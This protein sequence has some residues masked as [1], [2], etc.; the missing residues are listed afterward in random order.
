MLVADIRGRPGLGRCEWEWSGTAKTD[1]PT[2]A[3]RCARKQACRLGGKCL[4]VIHAGQAA[5]VVLAEI[6]KPKEPANAQ[7]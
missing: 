7:P 6:G 2:S 3:T 5:L 4:C 1:T